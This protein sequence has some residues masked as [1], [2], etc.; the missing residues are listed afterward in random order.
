[1]KAYIYIKYLLFQLYFEYIVLFCNITKFFPVNY[2]LYR[3]V[4]SRLSP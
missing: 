4:L 3:D 2:P 1:M